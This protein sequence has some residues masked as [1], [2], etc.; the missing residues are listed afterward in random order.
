M[1]RWTK[2]Q[3]RAIESRNSNLLVSAGAG[4]G[5]TA[6]LVERIIQYLTDESEPIDVDRLLVVTFTNAAAA[7]M[8]ERIGAA[9]TQKLSANPL[10]T[11]LVRQITL[12]GRASIQTLHSFCLDLVRQHFYLLGLDPSFRVADETEAAL[13]RSDTIEELL[14]RHYAEPTEE[15]LALVE[16]FGG[17]NSDDGVLNLV[18]SLADYA[19][20]QPDP[21]QWLQQ[22]CEEFAPHGRGLPELTWYTETWENVR[23]LLSDATRELACAIGIAGDNG[24]PINYLPLLQLEHE[25]LSELL[26]DM[27]LLAWDELR[28]RIMRI[29]FGRLP[30]RAGGSDELK[31]Q[32]QRNRNSAKDSFGKL[33]K[34]F[35]AQSEAEILQGLAAASPMVTVLC[36]LVVQYLHAFQDAKLQKGLVDFADLEHMA[37]RILRG[38]AAIA[39][40]FQELFLEVLIDEYQDV[41][42]VQEAILAFVARTNNRFMVGDVKQSIYRFRLAEPNLFIEKQRCYGADPTLGQVVHL[43]DNFRSRPSVIH[44]VNYVFRQLMTEDGVGEVE[45]SCEAELRPSSAMYPEEQKTVTQEVELCLLERDPALQCEVEDGVALGDVDE[46]NVEN[47]ALDVTAREAQLISL[48]IQDMV[49][50]GDYKVWDKTAAA[51]RGVEY[52]DIVVLLRATRGRAESFVEVFRSGGVPVYADTNSG[53][54]QATEISVMLSLLKIIDNP[55]QD[56]PLA[57]VLRSPMFMFSAEDLAEIRLR[58]GRKEYW[59][60]LNA[61]DLEGDLADRVG[62]FLAM[63]AKWRELARRNSLPEL[64]QRIFA[65]TAIDVYVGA[66]PGGRQRQANLQALYERACQYEATSFR[67]LFRFLRFV[68]RLQEQNGDLGTAKSLGE[69]ENVVRVMSIHKSKGLEF[70]IVFIAGLG[71][72]FNLTDKHKPVLIHKKLGLGPQVV[73]LESR[74]MYPTLPRLAIERRLHVESLSEE[75]RVLYVA[76]T[77]AREKLYLVGSIKKLEEQVASWRDI[78]AEHQATDTLPRELVVSAKCFLDWLGPACFRHSSLSP[79]ILS[80]SLAQFTLSERNWLDSRTLMTETCSAD[81]LSAVRAGEPV[82]DHGYTTEVRRRLS[83]H[84]PYRISAGLPGKV[85]V[86]EL[87]RRQSE[88]DEQQQHNYGS[89]TEVPPFV[90]AKGA[91]TPAEIGTAMHLVMQHV[92]FKEVTHESLVALRASMVEK[93]LLTPDEAQAVDLTRIFHFFVSD[94]GLRLL[95]SPKYWREIPFSL[96][97][98]ANEIHPGIDDEFVYVQGVIDCLFQ[99]DDSLILVDYKSDRVTEDSV[100]QLVA[101][102]KVQLDLYCRAIENLLKR[103]VKER[104]LYLFALNRA[105][106]L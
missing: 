97:I 43:S 34:N 37:L 45:Y 63:Y 40:E 46:Q 21:E 101:R 3:Q 60:C 61:E 25:A 71:N 17:R 87:K 66:L 53:Y 8:R 59:D 88:G 50:R 18:W 52:R 93:A 81:L 70:P 86:T 30:S 38:H 41:N 90:Q 75:L 77:R 6:V 54:F 72:H 29:T 28:E 51:Y 31:A 24:G 13:I 82:V 55:R 22:V 64:I 65:D 91:L 56:I 20:S 1:S 99:E 2:D 98:P 23:L 42:G 5:K 15:F 39:A 83:W 89:F 27:E 76:M 100:D 4:A 19:Q 35:F 96:R 44:A 26:R 7:E 33:T 78:A 32:C 85:S 92:D 10:N 104:Y 16:G 49:E 69:S 57:S 103:P 11:H 12:L 62:S 106:C 14:E 95:K 68:E 102:Y 105:I 9:I 36:E 79:T 94:I 73:D 67:G 80:S 48:K 47:D 58:G 74:V 84:Y